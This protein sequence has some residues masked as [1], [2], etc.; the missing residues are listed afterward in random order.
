MAISKTVR[1]SFLIMTSLGHF[2]L[3]LVRRD[4]G[5]DSSYQKICCDIMYV[6]ISRSWIVFLIP[7]KRKLV[8]LYARIQKRKHLSR[9]WDVSLQCV[10]ALLQALR[11]MTKFKQ[12]L[13]LVLEKEDL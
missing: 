11:R 13:G 1:L 7:L 10:H 8:N 6:F 5:R 9:Q 3:W 2:L 4:V 12:N